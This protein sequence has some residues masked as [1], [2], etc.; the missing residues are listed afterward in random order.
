MKIAECRMERSQLLWASTLLGENRSTIFLADSYL[1]SAQ[2][3]SNNVQLLAADV[4]VQHP[5][6]SALYITTLF[7][8]S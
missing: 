2:D 1:N 8:L 4:T 7:V 5:A 3:R 6:I